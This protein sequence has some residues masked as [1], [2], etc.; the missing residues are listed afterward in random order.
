MILRWIV[1]V[2]MIA[3]CISKIIAEVT[4][5]GPAY[6]PLI[7]IVCPIL[8]L[9]GLGKRGMFTWPL[10]TILLLI[11]GHWIVGWIPAALVVFTVIGNKWLD[12]KHP[13]RCPVCNLDFEEGQELVKYND[14]LVHSGECLTKLM[15]SQAGDIRA[16]DL[17][18]ESSE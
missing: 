7:Y 10:A 6:L 1:L 13:T 15:V 12:K 9:A 2:A 3:F 4:A 18:G 8:L 14:I 17:E 11:E 5:P 16:S